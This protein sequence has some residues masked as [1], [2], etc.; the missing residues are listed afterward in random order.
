MNRTASTMSGEELAKYIPPRP[1][2]LPQAPAAAA[3]APVKYDVYH[4]EDQRTVWL[5]I[6][7]S[8]VTT[9]VRTPVVGDKQLVHEIAHALNC[10][11]LLRAAL[12]HAGEVLVDANVEAGHPVFAAIDKALSDSRV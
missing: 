10:H 5:S 4:N 3:P 11:A 6:V 8:P 7:G 1:P 9:T 12:A 2:K